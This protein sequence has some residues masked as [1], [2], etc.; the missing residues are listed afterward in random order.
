[1]GYGIHS[2]EV[3][4][5]YYEA[6]G[7]AEFYSSYRTALFPAEEIILRAIEEEFKNMPILEIGVGGGRLVPY[8]Q[9]ISK[10]YIGVDYSEKMIELCRKEFEGITFLT[11][12]ATNMPIFK[13]GQF[14]VVVFCGNG[15]DD[16]SA[17]SRL[18]IL[19]ECYRILKAN[20]VLLFS[21]HN[22][23]RRWIFKTSVLEGLTWKK[24]YSAADPLRL[25]A[26][27]WYL[28]K[29]SWGWISNKGYMVVPYYEITPR[30][31]VL[32]TYWIRKETQERQLLELGFSNINA[33]ATDGKP[34]DSK[35]RYRDFM[36]FY[37]ARKNQG[38]QSA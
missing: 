11:C 12:D 27:G 8:L 4:H 17:Q 26:F 5:R 9:A 18:M 24:W 29:R 36:V 13:E 6:P 33:L 10:D 22:L 2:F 23:D 19:R 1:M 31:A 20:G 21:T 30:K 15:L 28:L 25:K 32:P 3:N 34:L 37:N 14:S 35:N 7:V 38:D 16:V